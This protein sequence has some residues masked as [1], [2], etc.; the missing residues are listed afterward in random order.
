MYDLIDLLEYNERLIVRVLFI[1]DEIL[2]SDW[3]GDFY[4]WLLISAY[5]FIEGILKLQRLKMLKDG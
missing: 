4:R 1:R 3:R 5:E 2:H